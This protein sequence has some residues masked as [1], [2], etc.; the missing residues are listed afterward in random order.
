MDL[1]EKDFL[2]NRPECIRSTTVQQTFR[3]MVHLAEA[4]HLALKSESV[5]QLSTC[6]IIMDCG[7]TRVCQ[8]PP[9]FQFSLSPRIIMQ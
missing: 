1:V 9:F 6:L 5:K 8:F 7:P 3:F 2:F 4:Y